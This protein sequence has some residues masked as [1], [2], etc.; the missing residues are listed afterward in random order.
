M[1]HGILELQGHGKQCCARYAEAVRP[2][3]FVE[4]LFLCLVYTVLKPFL[5]ICHFLSAVFDALLGSIWLNADI[6]LHRS[7]YRLL[8]DS[9][10]EELPENC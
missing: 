2:G 1:E 3:S 4:A 6:L 5:P 7:I 10:P 8:T 9:L